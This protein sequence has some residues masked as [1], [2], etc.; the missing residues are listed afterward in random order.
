M[1]SILFLYILENI[2]CIKIFNA[3]Y[4]VYTKTEK[5]VIAIP[6]APNI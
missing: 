6:H 3:I 1:V 5:S 4:L 2:K